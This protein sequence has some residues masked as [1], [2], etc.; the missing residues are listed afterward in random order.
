MKKQKQLF[1]GLCYA[2]CTLGTSFAQTPWIA[3]GNPAGPFSIG[4]SNG[5]PLNFVTNSTQRMTIDAGFGFVGIGNN[6]MNPLH[7]LDVRNGDGINVGN[8]NLT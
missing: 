8:K 1:L 6:F 4:L 7:Q 2:L 3:N 5:H